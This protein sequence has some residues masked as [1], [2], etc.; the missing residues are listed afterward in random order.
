MAIFIL[1]AL[2]TSPSLLA[3]ASAK[4]FEPET[5]TLKNGMQVVVIRNPRAPV[6]T[7]MVWYKVG[8]AD[9]PP[10]QSGIA[11][12]LEHLMFTRT[13]KLKSGEFVKIVSRNGGRQNAITGQDFTYYFQTVAADRLETMMRHEAD[14]MTGLVLTE[15]TIAP[16]RRVVLRERNSRTDSRP[17][18][19]LWEQA[20]AAMYLNHPY[21]I[22]IFGW[23]H[24]I[25][26]L[27]KDQIIAFYRRYYAPNNAILVVTGD[28]TTARL[29]PLAEKYYGVIPAMATPKRA[30]PLEPPHK[31]VRRVIRRDA[32]VR[33]PTVGRLYLAPGYNSPG[34]KHAYA[35]QILREILDGGATSRLTRALIVEQ[36]LA[37]D[38]G[39]GYDPTVV[40]YV[41]FLFYAAPRPGVPIDK[42]EAALDAVLAKLLKDGI[43][44]E[45]LRRAK[46]RLTNTAIFARDSL[47]T[48]ARTLGRAL[49]VGLKIE[50]VEKWPERIGAVTKAEVEAAARAVFKANSSVPA[51]LLPAKAK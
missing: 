5:F 9:E 42:L 48:G 41:T 10:G 20:Y 33:Q 47:S 50:D 12:L 19:I 39:T 44:E 45:E 24:E 27:T 28:I 3:P 15:A 46:Q 51:I 23:A 36:K 26:A 21:R 6:V 13:K 32:R 40:D 31:A 22:P 18:M 11:H 30:R 38:I 8:A 17:Q 25:E 14:R 16:V 43:T 1:A 49:A 2:L 37:A 35:L 29:R 4:V 34:K 7:H